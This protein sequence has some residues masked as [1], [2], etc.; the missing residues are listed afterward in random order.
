MRN[1]PKHYTE[2]SNQKNSLMSQRKLQED[3]TNKNSAMK[4]LEALYRHNIF[5]YAL[6]TTQNSERPLKNTERDNAQE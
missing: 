6:T 2:A 4:S 1:Q 5:I 3:T